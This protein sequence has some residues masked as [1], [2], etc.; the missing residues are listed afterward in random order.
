MAV[1]IREFKV[2]ITRR[3]L[4]RAEI[5]AHLGGLS[6]SPS[7]ERNPLEMKLAFAWR[8]F[9]PGLN[10]RPISDTGLGFSALERG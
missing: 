1:V 10:F 2:V 4:A 6:F 8:R 3:I 9:Q 5:S 7:S